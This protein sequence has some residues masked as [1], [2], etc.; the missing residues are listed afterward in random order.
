MAHI[1]YEDE[2]ITEY[3][4]GREEVRFTDEEWAVMM[5]DPVAWGYAC[6][7]GHRIDLPGAIGGEGCVACFN[8]SESAMAEEQARWAYEEW[9]AGAANDAD[10]HLLDWPPL[11]EAVI[12]P[13]APDEILPF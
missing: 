11:A 12:D 4:D 5:A 7:R 6:E 10:D 8:E 9:V 13:D 3:S 2:L 1:V